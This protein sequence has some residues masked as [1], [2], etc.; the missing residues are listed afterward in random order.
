[1]SSLHNSRICFEFCSFAKKILYGSVQ[2]QQQCD[3]VR[4]KARL[5]QQGLPQGSVLSPLLFLVF[6]NDLVESLAERVEV[7]AFADDLA[8][9][10]TARTVEEGRERLQWAA[11]RV[12]RWCEE[13]AMTVSVGKC[14]VTLLS[15]D[16]RDREMTE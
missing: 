4:S 3:G 10:H 2:Q 6:V 12:E 1:M 5:F 9:W 13:W 11:G 7:S 8:V 15:N 14:S 16:R